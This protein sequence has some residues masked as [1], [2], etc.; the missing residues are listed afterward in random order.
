MCAKNVCQCPKPPGGVATCEADQVAICKVIDG[1]AHTMC[2]SPPSQVLISLRRR[3]LKS[4]LVQI[5]LRRQIEKALRSKRG[6]RGSTA[7]IDFTSMSAN[8]PKS[9]ISASFKL[10]YVDGERGIRLKDTPPKGPIKGSG[11]GKRLVRVGGKYVVVV[12]NFV[13]GKKVEKKP[14]RKG[15]QLAVR[16]S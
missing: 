10:P 3:G 6:L 12:E 13:H 7:E 5:W 9:G 16:K 4:A 1:T 14:V 8:D 11:S 15:R 2:I